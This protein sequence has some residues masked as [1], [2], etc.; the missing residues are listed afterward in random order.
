MRTAIRTLFGVVLLGVLTAPAI[1][2]VNMNNM[3]Y[4]TFGRAVELGGVTL[5]AGTYVFEV[6]NPD[7]GANV[8]RVL[9][10]D[11]ARVHVLKATTPTYRE[12]TSDMRTMIK[13]G[14][15]PAGAPAAVRAWFPEN[16][17]RGH[18]FN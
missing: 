18:Q 12:R 15:A 4:L 2:A 14:E 10:R 17:T 5:P 8:V 11:R 7:S 1:E 9:S 6:A 13:L 16:E 3:T